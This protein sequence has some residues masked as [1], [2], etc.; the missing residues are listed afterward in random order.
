MSEPWTPRFK[1]GQEVWVRLNAKDALRS[2]TIIKALPEQGRVYLVAVKGVA[3]GCPVAE[4]DITE[5]ST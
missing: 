3:R 4:A 2:G 1:D 5:S